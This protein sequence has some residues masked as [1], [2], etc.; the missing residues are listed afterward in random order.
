ML[1]Q[2]AIF[3][4]GQERRFYKD[5]LLIQT[6]AKQ[7]SLRNCTKNLSTKARKALTKRLQTVTIRT[8]ATR[9]SKNLL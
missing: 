5:W 4:K 1:L 7:R 9:M 8:T 6:I 3:T 2:T